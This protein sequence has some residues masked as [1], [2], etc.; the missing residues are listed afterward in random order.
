MFENAGRIGINTTTPLDFLHARFSDTSGTVT[1]LAVQ[2][3]SG[4]AGSYSGMLF[5]DQN[6]ALGQFQGFNNATHEYRINNIASG[7]T[8]NVM[9]NGRTQLFASSPDQINPRIGIGTTTPGDTLD[10]A[11]GFVRSAGGF[12]MGG[13]FSSGISQEEN[14]QIVNIGVNYGRTGAFLDSSQVSS[15]FFRVDT[16]GSSQPLFGW[17]EKSPFVG[18]ETQR[19]SLTASG[20]LTVPGIRATGLNANSPVAVLIDANGLMGIATSSR[21]YK[22]DIADMGDASDGLMKLR[23]VTF[24][25]K[26]AGASVERP[27]EYGL[28]AEEV[29]A[30]YPGLVAHLANGDVETVQYHKINA[31]LLN[32]VQKQHR[33]IGTQ[34]RELDELRARL[35]ELE[36]LLATA[37]K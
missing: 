3:L 19:M 23:P 8:I 16:R 10:V 32:E 2:N 1:G 30:V 37:L 4:G 29:D 35:T 26:N 21:R 27:T 20:L 12:K 22:D 28:I 7:G 15:G 9:L 25:Y 36:R 24:R 6:G 18:I 33:Q 11:T 17:W 14:N 34:Q 31:M 13:A 5:Y